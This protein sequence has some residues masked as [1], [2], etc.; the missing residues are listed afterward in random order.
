MLLHPDDEEHRLMLSRIYLHHGVNLDEVRSAETLLPGKSASGVEDD[1]IAL[2]PDNHPS[3]FATRKVCSIKPRHFDEMIVG[4]V[5]IIIV[6]TELMMVVIIVAI[7][8][9]T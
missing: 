7:T 5:M 2:I 3:F 6:A 8:S 1:G 4:M 9:T